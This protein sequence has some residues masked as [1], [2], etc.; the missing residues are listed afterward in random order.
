[1]S[2]KTGPTPQ[3]PSAQYPLRPVGGVWCDVR[4]VLAVRLDNMGD[5]LMT[6]PAIAA[7]KGHPGRRVTLLAS[8]AGAALRNHLPALDDV[9][10]Y[11]APWVKG[12]M[13]SGAADR[14]FLGKLAARRFD[15]AVIF[16]VCSQ[17]ALPGALFCRMAGIP[18]RLAYARE[19]PYGLLTDWVPETDTVES[20]MRH[21]VAR[22][23][24]L[25]RSVGDDTGELGLSFQ[26]HAVDERSA[27]RKLDEAGGNHSAPYVLLHPGSTAASR[28]YPHE[29]FARAAQLIAEQTGMQIV[30]SGGIE[31][32]AIAVA[33]QSAMRSPSVSLAGVLTIGELA[34]LI[35]GARLL[36]C[37]NSGPA[38][39]AAAVQTPVVVLYALTN[40]QH[41]P[42]QVP[43]AVLNR[44]VPCRH[45]QKSVC[46]QGHHACLLGVEPEEVADEAI[47]LMRATSLLPDS[48][49]NTILIQQQVAHGFAG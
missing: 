22:Q 29:R 43:S 27:R 40:P 46:P 8:P 38:H 6:T 28:R 37:N 10:V 14:R 4:N 3:R 48:P 34:A 12:C 23:L 33:A 5:V 15:A 17:S 19:N 9:L 30:F 25:V 18:L 49:H 1:M 47:A 41:T 35:R 44:D 31:D 20:G 2:R 24:A 45:C 21:E 26:C 11:E 36:V 32:Q 39:L 13:R 42:W 7:L 16:T